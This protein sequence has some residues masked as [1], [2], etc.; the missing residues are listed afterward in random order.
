MTDGQATPEFRVTVLPEGHGFGVE[1]E[2]TVLHAALRQG[3]ALS[4]GCRFGGCGACVVTLRS[5]RIRYEDDEVPLALGEIGAGPDAIAVC[6]AL[7]MSDLVIEI[8]DTSGE[9]EGEAEE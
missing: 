6:L 4:W 9:T 2:E 3:V 7:P 1:P 5:G 8:P